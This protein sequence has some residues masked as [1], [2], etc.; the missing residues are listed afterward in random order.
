MSSGRMFNSRSWIT[1]RR[2]TNDL[3][4]ICHT[5]TWNRNVSKRNTMVLGRYDEP[6]RHLLFRLI[7]KGEVTLKRMI[8]RMYWEWILLNNCKYQQLLSV[9][10]YVRH[11]FCMFQIRWPELSM[12]I[13]YKRMNGVF[14]AFVCNVW[15]TY[16]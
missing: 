3:V 12:T 14:T 8:E 10:I 11:T 5:I 1:H 15:V 4:D 7:Y 6:G 13:L 2:F 9:L 16:L